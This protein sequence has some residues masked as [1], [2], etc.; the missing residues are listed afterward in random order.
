MYVGRTKECGHNDKLQLKL[1]E[2]AKE[3]VMDSLE[4]KMNMLYLLKWLILLSKSKFRYKSVN[5][6]MSF[7]ELGNKET[8]IGMSLLETIRPTKKFSYLSFEAR[9]LI[10]G[11][12]LHERRFSQN[13]LCKNKAKTFEN[14]PVMVSKY[15]D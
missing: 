15:P 1:V 2:L 14:K 13:E 8:N 4:V 5:T 12:Y 11:H 3:V 6:E 10:H 7:F 9:M